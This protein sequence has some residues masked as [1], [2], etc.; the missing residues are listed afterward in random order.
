MLISKKTH[1]KEC[2]LTGIKYEI[3]NIMHT[4]G[5]TLSLIWP[6]SRGGHQDFIKCQSGDWEACLDLASTKS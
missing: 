1:V 5:G 2:I 4:S 6:N 3:P